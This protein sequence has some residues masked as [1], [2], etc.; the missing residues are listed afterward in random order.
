MKLNS[1]K[2]DLNYSFKSCRFIYEPNWKPY[3]K[4]YLLINE[5]KNILSMP[6]GSL[7][8]ITIQNVT[9]GC[10]CTTPK[11]KKGDILIPGSKSNIVLG[12][13]AMSNGYFEKHATIYFSNGFTKQLTFK[14]ETYK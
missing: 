3:T 2:K 12:F 14:G 11:F 9:V 13:N 1:K 10:G 7:D 8:T 4:L 6:Q 5:K